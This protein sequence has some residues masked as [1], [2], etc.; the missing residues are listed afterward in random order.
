M[1]TSILDILLRVKD[2]ATQALKKVRGAAEDVNDEFDELAK[3]NTD[4]PEKEVKSLADRLDEARK[5]TNALNERFDALRNAGLAVAGLGAVIAGPFI[6][7]LRSAAQFSTQIAEIETL[8]GGA[9]VSNEELRTT[10]LNLS[11]EFGQARGDVAQGLYQAISSGARA[12]A[13]AN[14]VLRVALL[15]ARGGVTSVA[16]AVN[17][18]STIL[19]AFQLS[20]G[21]AE[22]VADSLFTAVKGGRTT[23]EE[24][25]SFLFQAAPLASSLGVGF[26]DLNAALV[27]VTKQGVP[28]RNAF[29]QIRSALQGIIRDTPELA[30]VFKD[31]G[32]SATAAIQSIGLPAVLD[33]VRAAANGSEGALIKLIGSIEGANAILA[34]TGKNSEVYAQALRDQEQALGAAAEAAATVEQAFGVRLEN[35]LIRITNLFTELGNIVGPTIADIVEV[36]GEFAQALITTLQTNEFAQTIAA[37]TA[38]LGFFLIAVGSATAAAF[39]AARGFN[40]LR[41]AMTGLGISATSA[42]GGMTLLARGLQLAR[43]ALTRIFIPLSILTF[44]FDAFAGDQVDLQDEIERTNEALDAQA[45]NFANLGSA[46]KVS[47]SSDANDQVGRLEAR[48]KELLATQERLK[49][50]GTGLFDELL[51]KGNAEEQL[52]QVAR[53]IQDTERQLE[54]AKNRAA[55]LAEKLTEVNEKGLSVND[56]G[57]FVA[58]IRGAE[59]A[60]Q[61]LTGDLAEANATL[62]ELREAPGGTVTK[63]FVD[64]SE[65]AVTYKTEVSEAVKEQEKFRDG[66]VKQIALQEQT[67]ARATL[68]LEAVDR[69][70]AAE[71]ERE[72]ARRAVETKEQTLERLKEEEKA[73]RAQ[74]RLREVQARNQLRLLQT[75]QQEEVRVLQ[76]QLRNKEISE[77]EYYAARKRLA[78][79]QLALERQITEQQIA[80]AR[81]GQ[82]RAIDQLNL[83]S[84]LTESQKK[85]REDTITAQFAAEISTLE[86]SLENAGAQLVNT[87]A[88]VS[89]EVNTRTLAQVKEDYARFTAD[90]KAELDA[91]QVA[92][93]AGDITPTEASERIAE[94]N[95]RAAD[96]IQR[97]LIP[98]VEAYFQK[99]KDPSALAF[100]EELSDK[101]DKLSDRADSFTNRLKAASEQALAGFF[102]ETLKDIDSV[103]EAFDNLIINIGDSIRQLIAQKLANKLIESLFGGSTSVLGGFLNSS[104]GGAVTAASGGYVKAAGGG[105]LKLA[106]GGGKVRG[107]GTRTSDSIPAMLSAGEYVVKADAVDHYGLQFLEAINRRAAA[108]QRLNRKFTVTTPKRTRFATGGLVGSPPS[109]EEVAGAA[110]VASGGGNLELR[111]DPQTANMLMRDVLEREFGKILRTR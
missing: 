109:V 42:A 31:F 88:Q 36:V 61:N 79:A 83:T 35:A 4:K 60:V 49:T 25:S 71:A 74:D 59:Q 105:V 39:V 54:A 101:W 108:P 3:K 47:V 2:Q 55:E 8:V 40:F 10:V 32:G 96:V 58:E 111:V 9:A 78:E 92:L 72:K 26:D 63:G 15:T 6:A 77:E 107:P 64:L 68:E 100:L 84:G 76:D 69:L 95:Q 91:V 28:T 82:Q 16:S 102:E 104:D 34:L 89:R 97:Q 93:A 90:L 56:R 24:L 103:G 21:D 46:A 106:D 66:L 13:E 14:E 62:N 19:N 30:E 70:I 67:V 86:G 87:L 1:A 7:G 29:T 81:A 52:A 5:E 37:I 44:A 98:A 73:I 11:S 75:T 43:L 85:A 41:G 33:R 22:R 27:A 17:G 45:E 80:N 51:G 94:A 48:L 38:S 20:A 12:G 23:V 110:G 57:R 50:S 99:T 53:S 18:L 65:L